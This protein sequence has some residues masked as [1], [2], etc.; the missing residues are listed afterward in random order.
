MQLG[1][2]TGGEVR[3][4]EDQAEEHAE[5]LG[6]RNLGKAQFGGGLYRPPSEPLV[7]HGCERHGDPH[8]SGTG[9]TDGRK[10]GS[11]DLRTLCLPRRWGFR[12]AVRRRHDGSRRR[13]F[14]R[15]SHLPEPGGHLFLTAAGSH[16]L[17]SD[18]SSAA[19]GAYMSSLVGTSPP[20]ACAYR[21]RRGT[22][23][24]KT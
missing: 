13:D 8:W 11:A 5:N 23:A 10:C 7:F 4:G 24:S 2:N 3:V 20:N 16:G 17:T 6:G 18:S 15:L 14:R 9:L 1:A 12:S 21:S 22:E 19:T